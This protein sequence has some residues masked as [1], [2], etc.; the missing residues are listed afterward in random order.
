MGEMRGEEERHERRE[1]RLGHGKEERK[2]WSQDLR[3]SAWPSRQTPTH[4]H[5]VFPDLRAF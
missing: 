4:T 5:A 3:S 2:T 1:V